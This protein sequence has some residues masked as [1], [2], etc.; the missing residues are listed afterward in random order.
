M[1]ITID[2]VID[3]LH[4]LHIK[5]L[6]VPHANFARV[7]DANIQIISWSIMVTVALYYVFLTQQNLFCCESFPIRHNWECQFRETIGWIIGFAELILIGVDLRRF[8][9]CTRTLY[10]STLFISPIKFWR[11]DSPHLWRQSMKAM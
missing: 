11:L 3:N 8:T 1:V 4:I 2:N 6:L 9:H 10:W 7:Y 5:S